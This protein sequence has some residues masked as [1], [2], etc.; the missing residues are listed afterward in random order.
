MLTD[1][2]TLVLIVLAAA[3]VGSGAVAAS[4][5]A[6]RRSSIEAGT[7]FDRLEGRLAAIESALRRPRTDRATAESA[8]RPRAR[9]PRSSPPGRPA[10]TERV[11][12]PGPAPPGPILIAVPD[13]SGS[14]QGVGTQA[15]SARRASAV[16]DLSRRFG[17]IWELADTGASADRIAS[18]TGRPVGEVQLVLDLRRRLIDGPALRDG[19]VPE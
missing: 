16:A 10:S 4:W 18:T 14:R 2:P 19:E 7:R 17:R 11:D 5:R 9:S 3:A 1:G 6:A 12:P 13:L 15:E 8:D